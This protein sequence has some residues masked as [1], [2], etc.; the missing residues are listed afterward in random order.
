M[1]GETVLLTDAEKLARAVLLWLTPTM[2]TDDEREMWTL[3]T[4]AEY[5]TSRALYD[6]ARKVRR[7]E[8]VKR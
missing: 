7:A 2:W 1:K 8:E 3:L 6:L 5:A 4:G